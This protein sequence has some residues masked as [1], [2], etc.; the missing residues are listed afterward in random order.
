MFCVYL[1]LMWRLDVAKDNLAHIFK[2]GQ[3]GLLLLLY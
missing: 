3:M 1:D 2:G